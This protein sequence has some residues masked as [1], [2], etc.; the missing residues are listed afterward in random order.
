MDG[1]NDSGRHQLNCLPHSYN[2]FRGYASGL[3]LDLSF[4]VPALGQAWL[5]SCVDCE[6]GITFWFV[7]A[8]FAHS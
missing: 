3:D 1:G 8:F 6:S 4:L 2:K 5:D 7:G